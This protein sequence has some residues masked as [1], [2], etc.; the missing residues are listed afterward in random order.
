MYLALS[1]V[2]TK[3][4]DLFKLDKGSVNLYVEE[5]QGS[6]YYKFKVKVGHMDSCKGSIDIL[7]Y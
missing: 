2:G 3:T 1:N 5:R 4:V 7:L 6:D